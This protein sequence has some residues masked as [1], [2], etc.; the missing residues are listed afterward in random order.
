MSLGIPR[1]LEEPVAALF[2]RVF[3]VAPTIYFDERRRRSTVTVYLAKRPSSDGL[4]VRALHCGLAELRSLWLDF[5]R[6][7]LKVNFVRPQDWVESWKRHFRP[8]EIGRALLIKPSWSRRRARRGQAVVVLDPGL[9]FGTGRHAST[10]F[11]LREIVRRRRAGGA[12][13]MLDVGCGSG[14]L[15]IAAVKL[16]YATVDAFDFDPDAVRIARENAANNG[17]ARGVKIFQADLTQLPRRGA[18]RY[19]VVCANLIYDLLIAE[20]AR[21][22]ARLASDGVLVLAGIL[23]RQFDAV[24]RHYE[25]AGLKLQRTRREGEWRSGVFAR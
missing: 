2:E 7:R 24:R 18:Q 4:E 9:S 13:S 8:I 11:C 3:G 12:Q 16:D 15:G 19:S 10:A 20:S 25:R 1:E 14:I 17:A 23:D 6:T 21:L 22:V 5:G